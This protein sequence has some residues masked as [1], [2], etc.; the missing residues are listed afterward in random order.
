MR[1][2]FHALCPYF[3]MFPESF[4]SKWISRLT[5]EG[6]AVLDPFC[7][8]G[9][10]PFQA[11][12]MGRRAIGSDVNPVAYCITRAKTNAP[13]LPSVRRKITVLERAFESDKWETERKKLP[14]F[15]RRA[16]TPLTARQLLYL[17]NRLNWARSDVDCMIA[18]ITLGALHG[19]SQKSPYYLSNRMPRTISTKPGYSI[20][21][22]EKH[23][24]KPPKR[25][26]FSVLRNR[27]DYR[28]QS[29][30]PE[31]RAF[32]LQS[33]VRHLARVY[34]SFPK[35]LR[36]VVTSPPYFNVTNFEEDQWLR[37]WFLGGPP[38]PTYGRISRD[39]RHHAEDSYWNLISDMWQVLGCVLNE[40]ADVVIRLGGKHLDP[41]QIVRGLSATSASSK[42]SV[43]LVSD[44]VSMIRNRQTDVFRPGSQGCKFEV[45]CHF[46][47]S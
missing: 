11:L 15:F 2:R 43:T 36:C 20:R 5:K 37:L 30:P 44:E 23:G 39:D 22:W 34:S 27:V 35:P 45:D 19:E 26:A 7:G 13:K 46:R 4:A 29:S 31:M 25:D 8:R 18:A 9:T 28:Y 47:L 38:R 3:A 21:F 10:A 1:H 40:K 32:V 24:Y 17:R 14:E 33:D 41:E 6:E 16:Y 42:R 12:L